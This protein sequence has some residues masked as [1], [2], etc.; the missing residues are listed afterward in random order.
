MEKPKWATD[1]HLVQ[2]GQYFEGFVDDYEAVLSQHRM[3]T[4][5]TYGTRRSRSN[6]CSTT[7]GMAKEKENDGSDTNTIIN[8]EQV[9]KVQDRNRITH[10][11]IQIHYTSS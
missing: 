8:S 1:Y 3:S 7:S 5:T 6:L 11:C 10:F 2:C 4:V 9:T